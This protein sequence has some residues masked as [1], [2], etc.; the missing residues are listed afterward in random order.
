MFLDDE[1]ESIY[2]ENG[3]GGET[4][5]KLIKAC[6]ARIRKF[7]DCRNGED[8]LN[9]IKRV[10]NGWKLFCKKHP[11]FNPN[12]IRDYYLKSGKVTDKRILD[13]MHWN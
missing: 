4:S 7:E 12:G 2:Q 11:E 10:E 9:D 5:V 6:F 8:F 3:F 13:F 1:L